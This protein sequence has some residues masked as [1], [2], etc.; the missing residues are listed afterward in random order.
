MKFGEKVRELHKQKHLSQSALAKLVG[1]SPRTIFSYES[2]KIYPRHRETYAKLAD[3]L[4]VDGNYL[5][6]EEE[7]FEAKAYA[8]YGKRGKIQ[9]EALT[10][11][12]V[13]LYAG[14]ELEEEDMDAM[15]KAIQ[16]AYWKA[17]E[18]NK[19]HTPK[20]YLNGNPDTDK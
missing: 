9:A 6:A 15:L 4:D 8:K 3:A 10:N 1:V 2:G 19:R 20:K 16:E 5:L 17:K 12:L 13:A 7:T 14:G 18:I 11:E